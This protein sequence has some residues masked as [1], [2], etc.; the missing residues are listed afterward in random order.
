M[1][2]DRETVEGSAAHVNNPK[3]VSLARL[4]INDRERHLRAIN[5]A[6]RAIDHPGI[7][8]GHHVSN[9]DESACDLC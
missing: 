5:E 1:P 7:R 3:P 4:D 6:A 8:N 2:V 9:V